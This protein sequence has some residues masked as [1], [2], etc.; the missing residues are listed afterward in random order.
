[1]LA[2]EALIKNPQWQNILYSFDEHT[3]HILVDEFQDTSSLQW[4]IIDKLTE[5]WRSGMGAKRDRGKVP[6]IFLVGDD[7]QSIYLFRGAN[8]SLF[9]EARRKLS[10]WLGEEFHFEAVKQNYRSLPEI[11]DFVNSLFARLM[12]SD[13]IERWRTAYIP[14]EAVREGTGQVELI[15]LEGGESTRKNR[16]HE[17]SVLARRICSLN[18]DQEIWDGELRR[19]CRYG[20]MAILLRK[21]THLALYEEALRH[22]GIPFIAVK[23]IGFYDE[24]E[25]AILR[26]LLFFLI[27]PYDDHSLFCLLRS[28]LFGIGYGTFTRLMAKDDTPLYTKL[29]SV[30]NERVS[31]AYHTI[32]DWL[33]RSKSTP[34]AVILEDTLSE[35]GAWT[36]FGER[37]RHANVKKFIALIE[38]YESQGLSG[39]E[40][41]EKLI[42]SKTREESKAHINTEGMNAVQIM[43]IHAAK[44]LQFPIV[45][46]PALDEDDIPKSSPIVIDE[47]QE[48]ISLSYEDDA[49]RRRE[50]HDFRRRKE[51]ELEEEKR[52]FY[53][54]ATRA[55]DFLCMLA[56]PK[57][58]KDHAGRLKYITDNLGHLTTLKIVEES[59][60]HAVCRPSHAPAEAIPMER[61]FGHQHTDPLVYTPFRSWRDVTEDMDIRVKHGDDWILLGKVF[62]ILFDELSKSITPYESLMNRAVFL[63][64][65][66]ILREKDI[67]RLSAVIREDFSK[68]EKSGYL[69]EIIL[70]RED[71]FSELP[72]IY[73]KEHT[74]FRGRIDRLMIRDSSA[75]IYD[76][77]TFPVSDKEL[78]ELVDH[79]RFQMDIYKAAAEK[80]FSKKT[81]GYLLFTHLPLLIEM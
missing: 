64:K 74:V 49:L 17:A 31:A 50:M 7:K 66:E 65:N 76:Y 69:K 8:V 19:T 71:T 51:K 34:F 46:L 15:L 78:P 22:H 4:R 27:D 72:F 61:V 11:I 26:E 29:G 6:T 9:H 42:Q 81:K 52:L 3:D 47:D 39:L 14:F 58:G 75:Y 54:A 41:R 40:I 43:T 23:G 25:V 48:R 53:V 5:E 21:R 56:A 35:T 32:S 44:G 45:F 38:E 60:I 20:D 63:L 10:E 1:M 2:Y 33:E 57:K 77:K 28:P 55:R 30:R 24:P 16:K 67:S 36:Y 70:P 62:H 13:L 80:L 79:Y 59:D 73:E 12:P 37:Q 18:M 68:L